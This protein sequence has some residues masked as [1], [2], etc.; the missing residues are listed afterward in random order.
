M[1]ADPA[2]TDR[3]LERLQEVE[4]KRHRQSW[5]RCLVPLALI[6]AIGGAWAISFFDAAEAID[7][8]ITVVA[9]SNV[10]GL[11]E[12]HLAAA[13]LGPFAPLPL[14]VSLLL[15]LAAFGWVRT[16]Q[17]TADDEDYPFALDHLAGKNRCGENS[18]PGARR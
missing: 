17:A 13:L 8:S 14:L 1:I 4:S 9:I 18:R 12:Q 10:V 5:L 16:H 7:L 15:L 3:I 6:F 11:Q 2:F